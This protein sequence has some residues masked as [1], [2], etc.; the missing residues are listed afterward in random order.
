MSRTRQIIEEYFTNIYPKHV[1][2]NFAS[3]LNEKKD[4]EEKDKILLEVWNKLA[5]E[6]DSSTE[7]SFRKLQSRISSGKRQTGLLPAFHRLLKIAAVF[8]LPVLSVAATYLYMKKN[9]SAEDV[10]FVEYT[11]PNGEMR[12]LVLP[13]SSAVRLNSGS[14][15]I[16]P[17]HFGRTRQVYLNGEAYFSV[18]HNDRQPFI[19]TTGDLE[20][21]VLG[22]VFNISSYTGSESSSATLEEGKINVHL[23]SPGNASAVLSAAS[24][25][26]IYDRVSGTFEKQTVKIEDV[27]AWTRGHILIQGLSIEEIA[28]IIERRYA[29]KVYLN[30]NRY[31][32]EKITMKFMDGEDIA[33]FMKV[34]RCLVPG[35]RY[36][37]E[38]DKLYI[39]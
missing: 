28:K 10:K 33:E 7:E 4:R 13:D 6:T 31:K 17:E 36:K 32:D 24:E 29:M 9:I 23:K 15:L 11:V 37:I 38:N 26:L 14:V 3:W 21:E 2:K 27:T 30:L 1:Q 22:T 12:S 35:L 19:V 25:Q 5:F 34:L 39:Y 16:Y 20:V 8:L 18:V